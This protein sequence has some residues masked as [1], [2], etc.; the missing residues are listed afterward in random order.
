[1]VERLLLDYAHTTPDF[2]FA[3]LRYFNVA[4]CALDGSIGEDHEP[5][6]HLIPIVIQAALGRRDALTIFG[7]D[8][9]TPDGT[10]VRDYIHVVD[11][12]DAHAVVMEALRPG[13][14]RF[15]NLGIGEGVSVRELLQAAERVIGRQVPSRIG[16][17]RPGDPPLLY[18][19]ATRIREELGWE[20]QIT[21]IGEMIA[22]AW[23][24]FVANPD[25]YGDKKPTRISE[26]NS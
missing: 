22:S 12:A 18:A 4:G 6:T 9:D 25:G 8:Y 19:D 24:W 15:Y 21:D 2:A 20:A 10:C 5:E 13:D 11:L 14:Q 26:L 3:A 17:R 7:D 1:M 16:P 23:K